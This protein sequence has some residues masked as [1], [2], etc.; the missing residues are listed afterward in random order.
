MSLLLDA[1]KKAAEQKAAK[2]KQDI[3][4]SRASDE[5][6]IDAAAED[7]S[8]LEDD[9]DRSTRQSAR[10]MRDETE[11]DQSELDSAM[12]A[13]AS[14]A[15]D[16][17]E[18]RLDIPDTTGTEAPSLSAQ[19]QTGEDETIIFA[20]ED[21][22][23]LMGEPEYV[24]RET[25]SPED[26]TELRLPLREDETDVGEVAPADYG[27][28]T[29]LSQL[30]SR[31]EET[32]VSKVA[33]AN[34]GDETDLSQTVS[35][36]D[37]TDISQSLESAQ[38]PAIADETDLG[39]QPGVTD[40]TNLEGQSGDEDQTDISVPPASVADLEYAQAQ[41][42]AAAETTDVSQ[43][44]GPAD[45]AGAADEDMSLLLVERDQTNL[46]IPGQAT[47]PRALQGGASGDDELGLVDT[48]R[49][50]IPDD[51]TTA[52]AETQSNATATTNVNR[53]TQTTRTATTRTE[54][55][56]TYAPDNYDRTLMR[57]PSDDASKLFAG[58][59]SDSD[60]VMTP[61]YAKKVFQSK[62]SA[63]RLQLYK[64][65]G[66]IA[67]VILL[68]IGVYGLFEFQTQQDT[69][70]T[71][72]RPLKRDP[73]PGLIRPDSEPQADSLFAEGEVDERAL[74]L[75]ESAE[76]AEQPGVDDSAADSQ[77]SPAEEAAEVAV[78]EP[79]DESVVEAGIETPAVG[80]DPVV[81]EVDSV[82]EEV[83]VATAADESSLSIETT[84]QDRSVTST[85]D[86]SSTESSPVVDA[87]RSKL[88]ISSGER[89]QQ[90]HIWLREAYAAYQAGN[91][92]LALE[93]Y[94]KVL[95]V[96]PANRNALLARAAIH[97]QNN[98][99]NDAIRDYQK[100][101]LANP[102][103]A[104]AM[105]S[106]ITVANYS[107][108]ETETQL[109]LMIRDNPAS[110]YLNFALANAYGA[111]G[112][113]R[114]AQ[115]YYYLALQNNPDDPNYAYNLAVSLEHIAKPRAAIAYY[116][117]AL[118]NLDKGLA[119]FSRDV[120]QQRLE[121]LGKL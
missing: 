91:D 83:E 98:N 102:K 108:L 95:E 92:E 24:N 1:L 42:A 67:A 69:I 7:V 37:D 61:E 60:V 109:K 27:D 21:V 46:T 9:A 30:L 4:E 75:I 70:D 54:S 68:A 58:M 3:A 82:T 85:R 84:G 86:D 79:E 51:T 43:F 77:E 107:P 101:L 12:R 44:T 80:Q 93:L 89:M 13:T 115:G 49:H 47:D 81:Q 73:M 78:V 112:R 96:D 53:D 94:N 59:K 33:A 52:A 35:R 8:E 36:E 18:T 23:D 38:Q 119:T 34:Y 20:D 103:D 88:Q 114:E 17:D 76:R 97:V 65:Y 104:L 99:S 113:W 72:L 121:I 14:E 116:Q 74:S 48:T 15:E 111:Q 110:P 120:V 6:V 29:D 32:D 2:N 100:L 41:R 71:S 90:K 45:D 39:E 56:R 16:D 31:D 22:A 19:M 106:L 28:E 10:A 55:T 87:S 117:R 5:T 64:I 63:Q 62:S 11:V 50:R 25:R 118:A 66:G 26:E 40:E 105:A 57:L